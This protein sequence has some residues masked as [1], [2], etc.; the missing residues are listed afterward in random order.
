MVYLGVGMAT[1][2]ALRP[3]V[4]ADG[5]FDLFHPGHVA[6]LQ[7]ARAVGGLDAEL[8]VGVITD[9]D[10]RWKRPPIFTHAER[11]TM[12]RQCCEV[13]RVVES[14][15]L[16]LTDEFLDEHNISFV[17]HGDDDKQEHFFAVPIARGIM[18]YVGYTPGVS[19]T[20]I[21]SRIRA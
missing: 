18:R 15:P 21:I 3:V 4:Y 13:A 5:I 14:P 6:F 7:K 2:I 11:V 8:L 20:D 9:E 17:V 16:V 19:T 12:V 1:D 10:A